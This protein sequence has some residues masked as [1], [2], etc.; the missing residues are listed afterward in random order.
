MRT[1]VDSSILLDVFVGAG[2]HLVPAQ[3]GLQEAMAKGS[4]IV[5]EV[6]WAEVR[7]HFP[8]E[9]R[10]RR[11]METLG[12]MY[13]ASSTEAAS[14]AGR[15]WARYRKGGGKRQHLIPDFLVAAHASIHADVL[16]TR[17]RGFSKR[18]FKKLKVWDPTA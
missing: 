14:E 3:R 11:A 6:V 2:P 16:L 1:A 10:F 4:L 9:D 15:V 5:S 17:D 13:E 8:S 18:Y 7:A 12:I